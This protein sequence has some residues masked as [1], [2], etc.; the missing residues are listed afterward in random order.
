[1]KAIE[2][3]ALIATFKKGVPFTLLDLKA[4]F[5]NEGGKMFTIGVMYGKIE[6]NGKYKPVSESSNLTAYLPHETVLCTP[7]FVFVE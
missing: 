4:K 1:M 7:Y 2:I 6:P 5:P 3:L